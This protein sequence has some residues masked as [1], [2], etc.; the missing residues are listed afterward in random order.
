[1]GIQ[2][3]GGFADM[4][5]GKSSVQEDRIKALVGIKCT[6]VLRIMTGEE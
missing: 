4:S 2:C 5:G 6:G 1:M 3:I